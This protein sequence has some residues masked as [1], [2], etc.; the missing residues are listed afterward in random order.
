MLGS[1]KSWTFKNS[2]FFFSL[3]FSIRVSVRISRML[4]FQFL[5][6]DLHLL[7]LRSFS[8]QTFSSHFDS[9]VL[10][11]KRPSVDAS[12][13]SFTS[14]MCSVTVVVMVWAVATNSC[15]ADEYG[16]GWICAHQ[17]RGLVVWSP[18]SLSNWQCCSWHGLACASDWWRSSV[19]WGSFWLRCS[20]MVGLSLVATCITFWWV[21]KPADG[22]VLLEAA[23]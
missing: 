9:T 17:P 15:C 13:R 23:M 12:Q 14:R 1:E 8:P 2:S 18:I 6:K 19:N 20:Q 4:S 3:F 21:M 11:T 22:V 7:F 5:G 16:L 10:R